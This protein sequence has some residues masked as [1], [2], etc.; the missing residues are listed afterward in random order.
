M[1]IHITSRMAAVPTL[2]LLFFLGACLDIGPGTQPPVTETVAT[3]DSGEESTDSTTPSE[4]TPS[5]TATGPGALPDSGACAGSDFDLAETSFGRYVPLHFVPTG[6]SNVWFNFEVVD[7]HFDP[8]LPLSWITLS[9]A[10]GDHLQPEGNRASAAASV[11]FFHY[12]TPVTT[13]PPVQFHQIRAAERLSADSISITYGHAGGATA[14]GMTET[15]TVTHTWS[16]TGP[17]TAGPDAAAYE[18]AAAQLLTLDLEAPPPP[19]D[20]PA[21]LLGNAGNSR[22]AAQH[23]LRGRAGPLTVWVPLRDSGLTCSFS[24]PGAPVT[25][26]GDGVAWPETPDGFP[27]ET[28]WPGPGLARG[29]GIHYLPTTVSTTRDA[30]SL[31]DP[32]AELPDEALSRVGAYLVDTTGERIIF[33]SGSAGV[34][35]TPTRISLIDTDYVDTSRW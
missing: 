12:D 33:S 5:P 3:T 22:L 8:C 23:N 28:S 34:E 18:A 24:S 25:C 32:E 10:N 9:G 35:V 6:M 7:N 14:H 30:P 16:G 20:L 31:P 13:P 21:V 2:A 26:A 27:Q 29:L 11:I 4:G 15:F 19:H 17:V 1:S